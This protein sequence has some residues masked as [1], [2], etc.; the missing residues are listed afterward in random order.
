VSNPYEE[1]VLL[2]ALLDRLGK[3]QAQVL[4]A[5]LDRWMTRDRG[6][7]PAFDRDQK[8]VT[9]STY[10]RRKHDGNRIHNPD[11]NSASRTPKEQQS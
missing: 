11:S 9:D 2:G 7:A 1:S 5:R 6:N 3:A 10:D 8:Q 4:L